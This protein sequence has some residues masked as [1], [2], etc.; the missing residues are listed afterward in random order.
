MR[1]APF[2]ALVALAFPAAAQAAPRSLQATIDA[3]KP[4]AT[5][6]LARGTYAG[7]VTIA[8]PIKLVGAGAGAT[9]IRGGGPVVEVTP[10]AKDVVLDGLTITGGVA[11]TG[12]HCTAL[13]AP[14]YLPGVAIGGGLQVAPGPDGATG[15]TVTVRDSAITG[16]RASPI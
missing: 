3:A 10:D 11:T 2:L 6:K 16:N 14:D 5:V 8:K 12:D 13:C 4:G 1:S 15:A 7:P 9:V